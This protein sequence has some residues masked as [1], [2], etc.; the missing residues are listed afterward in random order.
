MLYHNISFI[1]PQ[2]FFIFLTQ[3]I[4]DLNSHSICPIVTDVS[5]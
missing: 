1:T 4:H 5:F 3:F 2:R